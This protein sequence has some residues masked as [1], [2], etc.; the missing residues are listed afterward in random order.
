MPKKTANKISVLIIEDDVFLA[1]LYKAKFELE[2][3]EVSVAHDGE[4]GLE[5]VAKRKPA[6]VLLDL[7]LPKVNGF[8][9]LENMK[10]DS[11]LKDIPVILLTNLSQKADVKRGLDLG[12]DDYL[13]KAHFMPSEVVAKIKDLAKKKA[14]D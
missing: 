4:K 7:I 5:I 11:G 13:I 8:V 12:A 14:I 10:K 1:D 9:V 3:F 2:G 6:V